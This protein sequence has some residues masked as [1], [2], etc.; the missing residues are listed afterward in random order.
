MEDNVRAPLPARQMNLM[1]PFGSESLEQ[2]ITRINADNTIE[3][4]M[5]TILIQSRKEY[6]GI[7]DSP[8]DESVFSNELI[9]RADKFCKFTSELTKKSGLRNKILDKINNFLS[10]KTDRIKLEPAEYLETIAIIDNSNLEQAN[11][12]YLKT[13]I[14]P[15]DT[16][17]LEEYKLILE[18]SKKEEENRLNKAREREFRQ[19]NMGVFSQYIN[20]L[21]KFDK[22]TE[23]LFQEIEPSINKYI[24]SQTDK[25]VLN[26]ETFSKFR[27]FIS[28]IRVKSEHIQLFNDLFVKC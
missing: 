7:D 25:V 22:Q 16:G 11:A 19:M 28:S 8:V 20:R 24:D 18:L 1:D 12:H 26:E 3:P 17:A 21:I 23:L 15:I 9:I 10:L 14:I 13:V 6:L 5:K 27:Q 2:Y 4:D